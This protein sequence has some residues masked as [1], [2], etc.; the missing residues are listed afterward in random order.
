MI[1]FFFLQILTYLI[2]LFFTFFF[3]LFFSSHFS[4][5]YSFRTRLWKERGFQM[6]ALSKWEM[7]DDMFVTRGRPRCSAQTMINLYYYW[8][9][10]F[11][12]VIDMQ[13][14]ELNNCF[15]EV[16]MKLLLCVGSL[17]HCDS[18]SA[19]DKEKLICLA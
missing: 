19:F 13:F 7:M 12:T 1:S 11:Y 18:F 15:N 16:K 3:F 17:N 6:V 10:L 4:S 2:Y 9:E 8:V 5:Y 14:K